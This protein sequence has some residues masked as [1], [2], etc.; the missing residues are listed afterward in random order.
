MRRVLWAL[1][2]LAAPAANAEPWL[3][4][5]PDGR[6]EFS[7][8]AESAS[9]R[10]C[11]NHPI[12]RGHVRRAPPPSPYASPADFP[13]IDTKTQKSRDVARRDILERELAEERKAL[14]EAI[15]ELG[16]LKQA[17]VAHAAPTIVKQYEER[18]RTHRTN[19]ANLERELA[20]AG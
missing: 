10:N 14:A 11:V 4:T 6:Q 13:R 18:I 20:G 16:E 9:K 1:L 19:I 3:C 2:A 8:D 5:L 17:R 7:Y 12:S 15:R